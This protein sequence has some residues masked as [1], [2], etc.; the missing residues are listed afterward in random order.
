MLTA[1]VKLAALGTWICVFKETDLC[2]YE[3]DDIFLAPEA[4]Q[5]VDLI[6]KSSGG[7]PVTAL[8]LDALERV[9]LSVGRH[10][11]HAYESPI[12]P[13][14]PSHEHIYAAHDNISM[15]LEYKLQ[16]MSTSMLNIPYGML[17]HSE[18]DLI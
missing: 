5:Q 18:T 11:L 3:L 2:I 17:L 14:A 16:Y 4:L 12:L 13:A 8:Q 7:F 6:N 1:I 10:H 15:S 9:D